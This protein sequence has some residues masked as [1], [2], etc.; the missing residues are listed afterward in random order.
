MHCRSLA[1]HI[2]QALLGA[3]V[4]SAICSL[5]PAISSAA[6]VTLAWDANTE[7]DLA[8][9]KLYYGIS[10]GSYPFS[11][12]VGNRTS[13]TLLGLL[14]GQFYYLAATAYDS[15]LNE[16]GFSNEVS[17]TATASTTTG[18]VGYWKFDEGSGTTTT[19]SSGNGLM[20]ALVNSPTWT[21]GEVNGA[22]AFNGSS[23]YVEALDADILSPG[24]EATFSAWVFLNSAP[25]ELTSVFNKW[26]QTADDEYLLGINP[27]QTLFFA[28]Q[29]TGGYTWGTPS[30]NEA[31]GTGQVPLNTWTHIALVR[32]GATL[33][34]YLNGVLD[35]SVTAADANPFRN[36]ITSLRL[37]GQSRGGVNR[38]FNGSLDEARLYNRA[39]SASEVFNLYMGTTPTADT[40]PPTV[41]LTAPTSGST[42]SGTLTV[43]A[44]ASDD[45]GVAGVQFKLDGT[46]L[47]AEV[48]AAPYVFSWT[49]TTTLNGAHTLTAVARDAAENTATAV[50]VSVTVANDTT[51]PVISS[52]SA[53]NISSFAAT[54][55]WAT[56]EASDS[57][58]EYG[59]TTA[60][61][62]ATVLNTN[63]VTSHSQTLGGLARNRWYH[64]R[65]KS[66]DAAGNLAVS[67]DFV[68]KTS[69]K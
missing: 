38:F 63:L 47:G 46:N 54:I 14:E 8:G 7:P 24:T 35:A 50:G 31:N 62:N 27:N 67:G 21:A 20:G 29:T 53:S 17:T 58:V 69:R 26:S 15:S 48:T 61:G 39:L 19:D 64:Y 36:G 16:S 9:Y 11:V 13:Y 25:T 45:V 34:F 3:C 32:S 51:P 12:D 23:S 6:Q 28:W 44:S 1:R 59:P 4:L 66:R 33:N 41:S 2:C 37:G 49:T 5:A 43:S 18:P 22:L 30:F 40:T 55:A 56:N 65:V 42:V 57:L 52:V 68:F 10:S 60:Y